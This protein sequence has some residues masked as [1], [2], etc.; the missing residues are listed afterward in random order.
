M[1]TDKD[2][3]TSQDVAVILPC[4]SWP[5]YLPEALDS[6]YAQTAPPNAVIVV[7]DGPS[8]FRAYE[9]VLEHYPGDGIYEKFCG[10]ERKTTGHIEKYGLVVKENGIVKFFDI[11]HVER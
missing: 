7:L 4:H 3:Y 9:V 6:V 1:S 2:T 10:Y 5:Q 8:D 11:I